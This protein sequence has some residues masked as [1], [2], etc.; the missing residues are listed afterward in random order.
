MHRTGKHT[1]IFDTPPSVLG[2]AA[3]ASNKEAEGPLAR[4]IDVL[5]KDALFGQKSWEKQR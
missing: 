1:I 3:V 4:H 5:G 2:Y